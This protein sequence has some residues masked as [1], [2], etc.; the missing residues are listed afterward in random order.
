MF[1][2]DIWN[3][4]GNDKL[5][6]CKSCLEKRMGRKLTKKDISQ[7]KDALVNIHNPEMRD[8]INENYGSE[9]EMVLT[10]RQHREIKISI[11]GGRITSIDN[12]SGVRFPWQVGQPANQGINTWACN[13]GFKIDGEDPCPEKKI[14]GVRTKDVPQGHEWRM[15]FPNKFRD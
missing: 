15:I 4:H 3:K 10:S 7:Y 1:N 9:K 5:T 2:D 8:L 11:Q 12:Q 14:F 13:N 6:L